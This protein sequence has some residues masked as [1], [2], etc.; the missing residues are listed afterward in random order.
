M[1]TI[2]ALSEITESHRGIVGA[3][4]ANLAAVRTLGLEVPDGFCLTTEAYGLFVHENDLAGVI[5]RVLAEEEGSGEPC[6]LQAVFRQGR[7]PGIVHNELT[8][9]YQQLSQ[10]Q[11]GE[12]SVA[13]RSSATVED[14][15]EASSAGQYDTLLNVVGVGQLESAVLECWASLWSPRAVAYRRRLK[16]PQT[17]AMAVLVQRMVPAEAAGVAF[18]HGVVS[19]ADCVIIEA[20]RGLGEALVSGQVQPDRYL[21]SRESGEEVESPAVGRQMTKAVGAESGGVAWVDVPEEERR[22]RILSGEQLRAIAQATVRLEGYFGQS[23]DVEWAW[24]G[25][26]LYV[27]QSRPITVDEASFFDTVVPDDEGIW[28]SGFLNERFPVPVSPL[29]WTLINEL[30][31]RLA[32]R[33]PLRY[34]G[35]ADAE[36]VLITRLYHGHPYVSLFVFQTLYKVFPDKLLP[37]DAYRYFPRGQTHLRHDVHYPHSLLDPRFLWSMLRH[38]LPDWEVWSPWHNY[39]R[40]N[41]FAAEHSRRYS[42]LA[43]ETRE[44]IANKATVSE[45]WSAIVR[46]QTLNEELLAVHRWTL[47]CTDLVYSLYRRTVQA[48]TKDIS[49]LEASTALITGLP[50]RSAEMDRALH[51]LASLQEGEQAFQAEL[52]AFFES[53]GHRSLYLDIYHPPLSAR[54]DQVMEWVRTIRADVR[55]APVKGTTSDE[56]Q[57]ARLRCSLRR[58]WS[59]ELKWRVVR[60]LLGMTQHYMPLREDQRYA[61][62]KVLALQRQLFLAIGEQ[63]ASKGALA[64]AEQVFFLTKSEI[65]AWVQ[66]GGHSGFARV[67]AQRKREF[68][69]LTAEYVAVPDRSYPEFLQGGLPLTER[70]IAAGRVLQGHGVSPGQGQGRVVVLQSAAELRR[71]TAG[72]VLVA[73]GV[74][75]AWTPVFGLL[76]AL[77]LEHGGQLSHAAVIAREYGLPA[78]AGIMDAAS[79]LRDGELVLVD[80]TRG[81]VERLEQNI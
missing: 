15:T 24:S 58:G 72:S 29:G 42:A 63:M 68:E 79:V 21:V 35:L 30:L 64:D 75:S 31:E 57:L 80:G 43:D 60:Y 61:W 69:R 8:R 56:T 4:A 45:L 1:P 36:S 49:A 20:A 12:A 38:L 34:L 44:L 18:S 16:L 9:A 26:Q 37:E 78:V 54:P 22:Q 47:T 74:D 55:R 52:A 73:P 27:L 2:L 39:R 7:L 40:W 3:K 33:D 5:A 81:M 53:Y 6:N 17:P 50:N 28:T 32:F 48:W 70:P 23:Q 77:V 59:G 67:A 25:E 46:L 71:V 62:Q 14:L 76:S 51:H 10:G 19:R 66:D 41:R 65:A 13:V 11:V